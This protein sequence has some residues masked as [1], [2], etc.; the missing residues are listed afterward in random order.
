MSLMIIPD[1][2]STSACSHIG[3]SGQPRS[4]IGLKRE[5]AEI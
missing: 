3:W 4:L 2:L 5:S 1:R